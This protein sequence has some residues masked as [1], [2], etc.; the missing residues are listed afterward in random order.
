MALG[1]QQ[2]LD[3]YDRITSSTDQPIKLMMAL[4]AKAGA[5]SMVLDKKGTYLKSEIKDWDIYQYM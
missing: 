5:K 3:S 4:Q 2:R 1:N